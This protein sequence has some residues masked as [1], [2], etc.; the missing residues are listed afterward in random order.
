MT[1]AG[2]IAVLMF[3]QSRELCAVAGE[4]ACVLEKF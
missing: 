4:T 3:Q 2:F 1:P